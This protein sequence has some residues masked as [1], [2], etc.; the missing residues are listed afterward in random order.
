MN[1]LAHLLIAERQAADPAGALL[2][3][4]ARGST[5][6]HLPPDVAA[7]IRL[8]RRVDAVFD[9][10]PGT[11]EALKELA[12]GERRWGRITL[13]LYADHWLTGN[14]QDWHA[15]PLAHFCARMASAV[16]ARGEAFA[17]LDLPPPEPARLQATLLGVQSPEGIEAAIGRI[18]ERARRP[19]AVRAGCANWRLHGEG[20][21]PQLPAILRDCLRA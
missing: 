14:W 2:G 8:H 5:L 4:A 13:D 6:S 9:A 16:A 19:A 17:A 18:A 20:L 10:H 3:D 21:A 11:H 12:A 1:F 15:E 7:S